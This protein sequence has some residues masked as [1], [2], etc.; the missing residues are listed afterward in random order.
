[1][2]MRLDLYVRRSTVKVLHQAGSELSETT[3]RA[4]ATLK[5]MIAMH[6]VGSYTF[7]I[8]HVPR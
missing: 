4:I 3:G 5:T 8:S 1:M 2:A 6:V 7:V